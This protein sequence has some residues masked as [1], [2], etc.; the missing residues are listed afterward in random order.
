MSETKEN[1]P[2]LAPGL[3]EFRYSSRGVPVT[4]DRGR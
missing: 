3:I 4:P 1:R 2:E